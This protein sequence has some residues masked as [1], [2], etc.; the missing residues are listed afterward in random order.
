[1]PAPAWNEYLAQLNRLP[2]GTAAALTDFL[3]PWLAP[4][5]PAATDPCWRLRQGGQLCLEALPDALR[6][7]YHTGTGRVE[8]ARFGSELAR[9]ATAG[10]IS[11]LVLALLAIAS[12][13]V[14][15]ARRLKQRLPGLD[16][17]AKD[18]MLMTLCRLCG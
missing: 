11:P 2:G 5:L 16:A 7:V 4:P 14:D 1:M 6:L 9:V 12:G 3:S 13:D 8:I 18:L 17:A 15:D 10:Q